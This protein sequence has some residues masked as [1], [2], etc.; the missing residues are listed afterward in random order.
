MKRFLTMISMVGLFM[1]FSACQ[2]NKNVS[3]KINV[4]EKSLTHVDFNSIDKV[5]ASV[6]DSEKVVFLLRH[7]ERGKDYSPAG[8]LTE[9]GLLQSKEVG[10]KI[11]TEEEFFYASSSIARTQQTCENIALGRE[12]KNYKRETWDILSGDW[13]EKAPEKVEEIGRSWELV[14]K[15]A[16]E[17]GYDE[18]FYDLKTRSEEWLDS[19]RA[20]LPDMKRLNVLISH[21]FFVIGMTVFATDKKIDLRHWQNGK[22]INYLAGI[23]IIVSP[24]GKMR[25]EPV[26][27]LESGV[28]K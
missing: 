11:K 5:F 7:G 23:A 20:R 24:N 17:G 1:S 18:A 4:T 12:E 27:G 10:E 6:K 21:D 9:R 8:L 25:L 3:E 13:Y 16:Y 2:E 14:S 26:R 22:W 19:L 28:L 15:W